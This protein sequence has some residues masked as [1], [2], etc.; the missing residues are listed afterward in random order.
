MGFWT[1]DKVRTVRDITLIA[2]I[3]FVVVMGMVTLLYNLQM[4]LTFYDFT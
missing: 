1:P 3:G 4:A 2:I